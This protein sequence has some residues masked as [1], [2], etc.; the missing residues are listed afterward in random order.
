M[1]LAD[2][3]RNPSPPPRPMPLPREREREYPPSVHLE[4]QRAREERLERVLLMEREMAYLQA[5][6]DIYTEM[7]A[8]SQEPP[9]VSLFEHR[10]DEGYRRPPLSSPPPSNPYPPSRDRDCLMDRPERSG[11]DDRRPYYS[12]SETSATSYPV[13]DSRTEQLLSY[14]PPR[15]RSG[16]GGHRGAELLAAAYGGAAT[17][18]KSVGYGTM[19]GNGGGGGGGAGYGGHKS[20]A[21]GGYSFGKS[22]STGTSG[23]GASH[24]YPHGGGSGGSR[25]GPYSGGSGYWN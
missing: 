13:T 25:S 23:W 19:S 20:L 4:D 3:P 6:E 12:R 2:Q 10:R 15:N 14:P 18:G 1:S 22:S 17:S 8:R 21:S 9:T 5:R 24:D 7:F 16:N 11:L